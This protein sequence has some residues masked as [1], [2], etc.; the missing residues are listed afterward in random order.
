MPRD[1]AL[2][3]GTCAVSLLSRRLVLA[4]LNTLV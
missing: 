2:K 1:I 3:L 4:L